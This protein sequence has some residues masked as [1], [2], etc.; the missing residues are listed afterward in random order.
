[1]C[2]K[3]LDDDFSASERRSPAI[4]GLAPTGLDIRW[5]A[6]IPLMTSPLLTQSRAALNSMSLSGSRQR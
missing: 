5:E 1:M 3:T 4:L 6:G 2:L